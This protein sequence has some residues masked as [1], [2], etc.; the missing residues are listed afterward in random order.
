[1]KYKYIIIDANNLGYRLFYKNIDRTLLK[2][3]NKFI[4]KNF[5][6]DYI[7]T[8]SLLKNTYNSEEIILLF[9]NHT[10]K[11]ELKKAFQ[12]DKQVSRKDIKETYKSNRKK[13]KNEFYE[14]LN[15]IKYYYMVGDKHY[16]T[17]QIFKLEADD[18]VAPCLNTIIKKDSAL[19]VT[20]DSDWTRYISDNKHYLP[21]NFNHPWT[22]DEFKYTY[23][24][25]P[26]EDSVILH[27]ILYGDSADNIDII[28][29]EIPISIREKIIQDYESIFDLIINTSKKSYM[30]EY[31]LLI[32]E[33]ES[34]L[35]I[36]YQLLSTIPVSNE[37]F[38]S[39]YTSGRES[40]KLIKAIEDI[41][42]D[43]KEK[44]KAFEFGGIKVPRVTPKE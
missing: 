7:D 4:Y 28:F 21:E 23:G 16:H 12:L 44:N 17:V 11:E 33:R 9:D 34:L 37:Q 8:V 3:S 42:Y 6:K 1:M 14:T 20:N 19:F 27:K 41:I 29:P 2:I 10:S 36:N 15:F 32:K 18:L 43:K 5:A 30:K 38:L 35:K 13:E 40:N 22:I 24:F 39:H 25:Y 26:N 31:F